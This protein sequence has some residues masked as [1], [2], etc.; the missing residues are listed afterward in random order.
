MFP[1]PLRIFNQPETQT[2]FPPPNPFQFGNLI[3]SIFHPRINTCSRVVREKSNKETTKIG[4]H[5][6]LFQQVT[7]V[8]Y[9]EDALHGASRSTFPSCGA[10]NRTREEMVGR[11]FLRGWKKL[12]VAEARYESRWT[13]PSLHP[14]PPRNY[15]YRLCHTLPCRHIDRCAPHQSNL[16]PFLPHHRHTNVAPQRCRVFSRFL[17]PRRLSGIIQTLMEFMEKGNDLDVE[18][19]FPKIF[20]PSLPNFLN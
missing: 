19:F 16:S 7:R 17:S 18:K 9:L 15:P 11:F 1:S 5:L 2:A 12:K 6:V 8:R 4:S 3:R 20:L 10:R 13:Y 14:P